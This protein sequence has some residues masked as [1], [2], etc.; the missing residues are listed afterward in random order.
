MTVLNE[1]TRSSA[2][3]PSEGS[4]PGE[5]L[6]GRTVLRLVSSKSSIA[7]CASSNEDTN[8]TP[9]RFPNDGSLELIHQHIAGLLSPNAL[10]RQ[11]RQ[12]WGRGAFEL[13]RNS[14]NNMKARCRDGSYATI[15][16][17]LSTFGSFMAAIGPRPTPAHSVDRIDN[18]ADYSAKNIRWATDGDQAK[19]RSS[20]GTYRVNGQTLTLKEAAALSGESPRAIRT[21]RSAGLSDEKAVFGQ[22]TRPTAPHGTGRLIF[23]EQ[24]PRKW[25]YD[26]LVK[27]LYKAKSL[28]FDEKRIAVN[29]L[30]RRWYYS[31]EQ[32]NACY[33]PD[34]YD[35]TEEQ[36][37]RM[38]YWADCIR[39]LGRLLDDTYPLAHRRFLHSS[40]G[41]VEFSC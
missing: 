35:P 25:D 37:G 20:T 7:R 15:S 19:N 22:R 11:L 8:P 38:V 33:V 2:V 32:C 21:R 9:S 5:P 30:L 28:G 27:A 41:Y 40:T 34:E 26:S 31:W 36:I 12:I 1:N 17:D 39:R 18:C 3:A 24:A 13:T 6:K 4:P 23:T 29:E 14:Y 10:Y 16:D